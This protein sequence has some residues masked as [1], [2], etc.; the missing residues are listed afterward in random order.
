MQGSDSVTVGQK[1]VIQDEVWSQSV[2]NLHR[3][4]T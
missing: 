4:A 1:R 2:T 3:A